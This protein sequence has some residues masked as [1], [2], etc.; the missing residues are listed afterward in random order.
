MFLCLETCNLR[1]EKD[2]SAGNCISIRKENNF[3][4]HESSGIKQDRT[5]K[6]EKDLLKIKE[7]ESQKNESKMIQIDVKLEN[8]S[9]ELET[10]VTN[11]DEYA[12]V[13][14][15]ISGLETPVILHE[16]SLKYEK[17]ETG[18]N[19]KDIFKYFLQK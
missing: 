7:P 16:E 13:N 4:D 6:I 17:S 14:D 12:S 8:S 15:T 1:V 10:K 2:K 3:E 19:F 9:E 18:K 11:L 5:I